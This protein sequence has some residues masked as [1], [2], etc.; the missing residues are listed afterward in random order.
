MDGRYYEGIF[1]YANAK[2][3]LIEIHSYPRAHL[4]DDV[5]SPIRIQNLLK[6]YPK[7][8]LSIAHLGGMQFE[9][10]HGLNA[11]FNFSAVLPDMVARLEIGKRTRFCAQSAWRNWFSRWIIRTAGA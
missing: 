10:L 2:N 5:C 7:V 1:E 6:K 4:P 9:A 11:Y 8:R 3:A